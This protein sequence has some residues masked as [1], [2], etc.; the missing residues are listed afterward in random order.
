MANK[1][2][3]TKQTGGYFSFSLTIDGVVQTAVNSIRNDLLTV[4]NELHFKTSN[5]ANIVKKQNILPTDLTVN[6]GALSTFTTVDQ[7]WN[8][9]IAISFFAWISSS[10]SGVDRFD[11]LLDTFQYFGKDG[12]VCVVDEAQLKI[13]PVTFYNKRY[14]TDLDD[15]PKVL[16]ANKMVVVNSDATGLILIDQ[17]KLIPAAQTGAIFFQNNIPTATQIDFTIPTNSMVISMHINNAF[18]APNI[19]WS[20]LGTTVTLTEITAKANDEVCFCLITI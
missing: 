15:T 11:K 17:P 3:I 1:L 19:R 9:L 6:D 13:K 5:G 14:F 16:S 8:K 18:V 20:L 10:N 2:T 7:V 12:Q 4:G